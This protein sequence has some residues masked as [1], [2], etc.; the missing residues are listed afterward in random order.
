MRSG[1][2][3]KIAAIFIVTLQVH[4]SPRTV[5]IQMFE[6]PW[7][8]IARECEVY[9][10]PAGF[11]AVQVS[12]PHE[13]L[14]WQNHP[15]WERYQVVSYKLESR[16]G[17][18][19][20]FA[21]MV[22]RCHQAGVDVYVDAVLNHTAGV[23]SGTG[24]NGTPFVHYNYPGLYQE[25]DFHHCHRNGNDDIVNYGD[26]WE[27]QN[28]E[29]LDLADLATESEKVQSQLAN[30]L[31]HLL[32]LGV[33]GFR[34]DAAKHIPAEDLQSIFS[35]LRRSAYIY[36]ELTPGPQGTDYEDYLPLGDVMAYTYSE[37][38]A[39]GVRQKNMD[40]LLNAANGFPESTKAIVF[41]TNHDLERTNSV[42]SFNS[43]ESQLYRLAQIFLLAWPYGYP[44]LYSGYSFSD[45]EAGPPLDASLRTLSV[46]D[47]NNQCQAPFTCEHRLPE[48]AAMVSFRNQ[49]N[50]SF[51]VRKWWSNHKDVL[52]FSRGNQG[53]VAINFGETSF[54]GDFSTTLPD[55]LY[56]NIIDSTDSLK[57]SDCSL[58]YIVAKGR[59]KAT[60]PAKSSLVL[61]Q[62]M[63]SIRDSQK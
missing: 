30:Y 45:R 59:I 41:L 49:T 47:R 46:L 53:F 38:L 36:S 13:H 42:L 24:F 21:D 2:F 32:D 62:K 35:R 7:K 23:P 18:E 9:L 31:N 12:P 51:S 1:F 8:D 39:N 50:G 40:A 17:S 33:T 22:R 48:V 20:D 5:F 56:C 25:Q 26:K 34:I 16:A 4:A 28:C 44:Q 15:W 37:V 43:E 57:T 61:L 54:D 63:T 6:W 19:K 14:L 3:L 29:L 60:L 55:G 11:A 27:L 52:A 10:G 58:K